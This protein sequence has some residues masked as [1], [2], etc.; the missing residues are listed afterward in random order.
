MILS[1]LCEWRNLPKGMSLCSLIYHAII[2]VSK[3]VEIIILKNQKP[4]LLAFLLYLLYQYL[5][6]MTISYQHHFHH[7]QHSRQLSF[8]LNI[9]QHVI[10]ILVHIDIKP[11]F[12]PE[13]FLWKIFYINLDFTWLLIMN[14]LR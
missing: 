6:L 2:L 8:I 3:Y 10:F 11:H 12:T 4:M 9:M 13:M 1:F 14:Y 5:H 7:R